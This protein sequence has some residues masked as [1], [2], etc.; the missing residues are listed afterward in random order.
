MTYLSARGDQNLLVLKWLQGHRL[1]VLR[2]LG[3]G[4]RPFCS[5]NP[6]VQL[7]NMQLSDLD[8]LTIGMVLDIWTEKGNDGEKYETQ[9]EIR[10]ANQHDCDVF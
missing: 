1:P 10:D 9:A 8:F 7:R 6:A 3:N 2:P 5:A 4:M